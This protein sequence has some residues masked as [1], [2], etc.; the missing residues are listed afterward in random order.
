MRK[1]SGSICIMKQT[2]K[3][4]FIP[5]K[6]NN[7][8]PHILHTKRVAFYGGLFVAMKIIVVAFVLFLPLEVFVM[9]DVLAGE[10]KKIIT[11]INSE[12]VAKG[13]SPLAEINPLDRSA[14][15]KA[16]DMAANEYFSHVGSNNRRL[17]SLLDMVGYQYR[18]A[19]ENLAMG[20]S[21]AKDVVEAWIKSP[22]HYANLLDAE[23]QETGVGLESGYFNGVPTVYVAQH[24]GWPNTKTTVVKT[25][26]APAPP[27]KTVA[28]TLPK[29]NVKKEVA[30]VIIQN[31]PIAP[32]S[33][34]VT[35]DK[36]NSKVYWEEK[37]GHISVN[38]KAAITG[39]V[40]SAT[41]SIGEVTIMLEKEGDAYV[42]GA[43]INQTVN[44]FFKVIISPVIGIKSIEGKMLT[45][46]ID[47]NSI[48]IVSPTPTAK[49]INARQS[50]GFLTNIFA[51]SKDIYL[52][53]IILFSIALLLGILIE[54]KIQH[55]RMIMQTA[56]LIS[57]LLCL[58]IL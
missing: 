38:V 25:A 11:L 10:Q 19:G 12:R 56:G 42:G 1:K 31:Q 44:E 48:K 27:P 41:V 54:I 58:Y 57:L 49:Y 30:A 32:V 13:L 36:T 15:L 9:P 47:W 34:A 5:H 6:E 7:Y 37:N 2:L 45:D 17:G 43:T 20:F 23:Y 22:T 40:E 53:F 3:K 18:S 29:K 50:L 28:A 35:F 21:S 33:A 24:F 52:S 51:V 39:A 46:T 55:P 4:Y 26:D 14:E 8:H 16:S